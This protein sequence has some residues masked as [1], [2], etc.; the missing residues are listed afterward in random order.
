[1]LHQIIHHAYDL[2]THHFLSFWFFSLVLVI[3]AGWLLS[4]AR[5]PVSPAAFGQASWEANA[6]LPSQFGLADGP[7]GFLFVL[8]AIAYIYLIFCKED[9]SYYDDDLLT[10]F[11]L[12]GKSF[13]PPIW[14]A[15][16]RFYPL[17]DQEFNPLRFVTRSP[18]GY[19]A[20]VV[21]QLII[22]LVVIFLILQKFPF[23]Y[24]CLIAAAAMV[25]PSFLIPFMGFVYP[26][27]NVLFGLAILILCLQRYSRNHSR[28]Y[29]VGALVA[30]HFILYYKETVVLFVVTFAGTWLSLQLYQSLSAGQCSWRELA[31]G[32]VLPLGLLGVA[33]I[34]AV[35][36]LATMLPQR[37][38]SYVSGLREPLSSV[39]IAYLQFDWLPFLLLAVVLFRI[40]RFLFARLPIDPL[41]DPLAMG[42]IVYF[43]GILAL[44][45]NSG[46]YMAP[47][48][49]LALFY[50]ANLARIWLQKPT[51]ARVFA[52]ATVVICIL[53]QGA[54]YSSFRVVERKRIIATKSHLADFLNGYLPS[55]DGDSVE[56]FFPYSSG[57]H[58]MDLASYL[59]Y[60]GFRLEGRGVS[61]S[62]LGPK[63]VLKGRETF[64]DNKC[65][66]YRDYSCFHA[67][68]AS[69]GALIVILPDDTVSMKE[70]RDLAQG[71][72][73]L[74]FVDCSVCSAHDQWFNLL[75]TISAEYSLTPLPGHWLQLHVFQEPM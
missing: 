60:K 12:Q 43:L 68:N 67:E 21:V 72:T 6:K 45:I 75:H 74:L 34:Y 24:Q 30:T 11:S 54:A 27:R 57:Y 16:G 8:F 70:V 14:A 1:M 10:E 59:N 37:H 41:W 52:I 53:A 17:A 32:N 25:T 7:S 44:R 39:L 63:L 5:G 28:F 46:Y 56:L 18:F 64:D 13:S 3:F 4:A 9:F 19:H 15:V 49:F 71:S 58:L 22:F 36:F 47:V 33:G 31:R 42:A 38:F 69:P 61:S 26:E 66:G 48:D 29:F 35:L 2:L 55:V 73:Q 50:L 23:R 20:L 65:V 62:A 51:Q 40:G